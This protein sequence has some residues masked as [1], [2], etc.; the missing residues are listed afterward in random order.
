MLARVRSALILA[1]NGDEDAARA[2]VA[3]A[4]EL[5]PRTSLSFLHRSRPYK[6]PSLYRRWDPVWQRLGMPE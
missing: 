2:Q 3:T 5:Y 6:D 4:V 1:H